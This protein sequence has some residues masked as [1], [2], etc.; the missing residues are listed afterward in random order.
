MLFPGCRVQPGK[1]MNNVPT[2]RARG[3][4]FNKMSISSIMNENSEDSK[5]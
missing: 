4:V 5:K 3:A 2:E 1:P